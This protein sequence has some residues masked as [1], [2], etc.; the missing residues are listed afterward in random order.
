M[1]ETKNAAVYSAESALEAVI[2][3]NKTIRPKMKKYQISNFPRF[4]FTLANFETRARHREFR[5]VSIDFPT[6][7]HLR[8]LVAESHAPRSLQS[9]EN[10]IKSSWWMKFV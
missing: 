7:Y 6:K 2:V 8:K 1:N 10:E 3:R 4:L 9:L 5:P